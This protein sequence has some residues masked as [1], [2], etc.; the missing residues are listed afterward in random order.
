MRFSVLIPTLVERQA[1][2]ERLVQKL[3]QQAKD[4]GLQNEIEILDFPDN[5]ENTLGFKRH[6][7]I[8]QA[9]G[10]FIAFV[11]DDDDISDRYVQLIYSALREHPTVDCV[12]ITGTVFF[13]GTH[14]HRFVYSLRLFLSD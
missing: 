7:L 4:D 8:A 6:E 9:C 12:G 2:F 5:R 3:T 10:E 1:V 14:P 13:R 11:D